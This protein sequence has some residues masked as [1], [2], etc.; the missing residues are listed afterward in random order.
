MPRVLLPPGCAGFG[1]GDR[2]YMARNGPGSFVT[3]DDTDP[4]ERRALQK[5]KGQDYHQAGL[6][7]GEEK[8]FAV[9]KDDGR[10]CKPCRRLWNRWNSSCPKCGEETV[11]EAEMDR[12]LPDGQYLPFGPIHA[13]MGQ[14]E[15]R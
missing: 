15:G 9:T 13:L 4:V 11:S 1:D 12:T 2:K 8:F 6:V 3:L 14:D 5:L 10:W 7:T